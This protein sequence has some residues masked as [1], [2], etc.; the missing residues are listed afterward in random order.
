MS[1]FVDTIR[2]KRDGGALDA[3]QLAAFISGVSDG[4]LPDYQV[5]AML[6]AIFQRGM[7]KAEKVALTL[8]MRDSGA[9]MDWSALEG[10]PV[11][12]H[13]TGTPSSAYF[14]NHDAVQQPV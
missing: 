7:T 10:V 9:V 1:S 2:T 12:K 14:D 6:M 4:S 13:S 8:G 11:D 5:A 3:E